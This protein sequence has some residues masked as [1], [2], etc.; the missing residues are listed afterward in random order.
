VDPSTRAVRLGGRK[1][2]LAAKEFALLHAL[3]EEPT[4]V[5]GKQ[6]LLRDVWGYL[7]MGTRRRLGP[8]LNSTRG[9]ESNAAG[10][11][12]MRE[13]SRPVES[14][15]TSAAPVSPAGPE[16]ETRRDPSSGPRARQ[17]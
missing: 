8:R 13:L 12:H 15:A 7:S 17:G 2:E 10:S 6:E 1:V 9:A 3:A 5:Y 16:Q 11:P 4:R 14:Y